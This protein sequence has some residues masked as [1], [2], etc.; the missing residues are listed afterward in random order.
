MG[1]R[2]EANYR[3]LREAFYAG[4]QTRRMSVSFRRDK[5]NQ[6]PEVTLDRIKDVLDHWVVQ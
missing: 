6:R 5:A 2:N 1:H 3:W 4:G